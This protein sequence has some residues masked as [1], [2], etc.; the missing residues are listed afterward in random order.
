MDSTTYLNTKNF[1]DLEGK[2]SYKP[3]DVVFDQGQGVLGLGCES[4]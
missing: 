4:T 2:N 1:I 3:L